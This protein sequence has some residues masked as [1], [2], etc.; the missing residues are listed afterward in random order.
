MKYYEKFFGVDYPFEKYDHVFC[1]E[2]NV[3]AMENAGAITVNDEYL[4]KG[5]IQLFLT[6]I[7][8]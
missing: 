6:L 4:F 7:I 1:P 5:F 3:G 8:K 2:Y